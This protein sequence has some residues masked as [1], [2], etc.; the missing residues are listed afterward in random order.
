MS[1]EGTGPTPG[2]GEVREPPLVV[3]GGETGALI[4]AI[5]W[6]ATRLGPA[7]DWP[8]SLRT[9]LGICVSSRFPIALYWGADFVM[10]YNDDLRPMVGANKHPAALGR[11]AFEVLPEIRDI[12]EPLLLQV[13]RTGEAVWAED[14]ML[15]LLRHQRPEESYFTFNYSPIGDESGAVGGVFCAV[16]ETTDKVIEG[17]RLRLLNA[18]TKIPTGKT[19]AEACAIA[20]AQLALAPHDVP[21]ALIY[22]V[23]D[24]SGVATLAGCANLAPDDPRAPATIAPGDASV[25]PLDPSPRERPRF[26]ALDGGPARGAVVLP[27]ERPTGG[28]PLGFLVAG[29]SPM[30]RSSPSYDQFHTLLAASLSQTVSNAAAFA[31]ALASARVAEDIRDR[32]QRQRDN[33]YRHF[34]Q[35]PFPVCVL[36]GAEHVVELANPLML[37]AWG[38]GAETV[39]LPLVEAV[40]ALRGQPFIDYLDEVYRTGVTYEGHAE[41]ARLPIGPDGALEDTYFDYVYAALRDPSGAIE[42]VLVSAFD[43]TEQ[44]VLRQQRARVLA[45]EQAASTRLHAVFMQAPVPICMLEGPDHRYTMA[46]PLFLSL[47]GQPDL[48][49]KTVAERF[50][51][52][53]EQGVLSLLD[54][55]YATGERYRGFAIPLRFESATPGAAREG[56]FDVVYEPFRRADGRIVGIVAVVFDVTAIVLAR[57]ASEQ[58]RIDAEAAAQAQREVAEFQERFVAV[59]GHDLRNPLAAIDMAAGLLRQ[60]ADKAGDA[61]TTRVATRIRSSSMRMSR[62]V[63][64]ILDFSRSRIGGGLVL[65]PATM[66]LC[67]M[68][69]AVVEELRVAHAERE[70]VLRCAPAHGTWDRDRLE[71]VFS[72]L[73]GNAI[74]HG[75]PD[76]AITVDARQVGA[77]VFVEVHNTGPAIPEAVRARLFSPFRRG[78]RD[79]RGTRTA[80]LGLGLYISR[81]L[82]VAHGGEI[83][84]ESSVEQGTTFRVTLPVMSHSSHEKVR[85]P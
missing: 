71:Q 82:V 25:W 1:R 50:P 76:A 6:S 56:L 11:P 38:K 65:T 74:H 31:S 53:V 14:L 59:L 43:V 67:P 24:A 75:S 12:I 9:A 70:I 64:Q 28:A 27:I 85:A 5:D 17:R 78:D 84:V 69:T 54:Q 21:F 55:V 47:V 73:I 19:P 62:M 45:D 80:G 51:R 18:L 41:L 42:G 26:V 13:M 46:N 49:G 83:D 66:E 2:D 77:E 8:Q 34:M 60:Q 32:E 29:L 81:E 52:R 37:R 48:V 7:R 79:S 72:N 39:G 40:P 22:L 36:R 68:L 33:L 35:A 16:L 23:D 15:P 20:A 61:R 3:G 4:R 58:A 63:E 44:T 57:R 10:L 30:L